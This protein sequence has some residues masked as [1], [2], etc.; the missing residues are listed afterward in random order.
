MCWWWCRRLPG[1][2]SHSCSAMPASRSRRMSASTSLKSF[3]WRLGATRMKESSPSLTNSLRKISVRLDNPSSRHL[4]EIAVSRRTTACVSESPLFPFFFLFLFFSLFLLFRQIEV[5]ESGKVRTD[6]RDNG[7]PDNQA[8]SK[9]DNCQI[10]S[11]LLPIN[12][13]VVPLGGFAFHPED[14]EVASIAHRGN[15]FHRQHRPLQDYLLQ[16]APQG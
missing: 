13:L 8:P 15:A 12:A 5:P 16:I 2:H 14:H 3:L 9:R 6:G 7:T 11:E 1:Q 4:P 10:R